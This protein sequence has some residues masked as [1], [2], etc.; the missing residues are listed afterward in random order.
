MAIVEEH[1]PANSLIESCADKDIPTPNPEVS[2][3]MSLDCQKLPEHSAVT[4]HE[5]D[6]K[7][8]HVK[9][10]TESEAVISQA[11]SETRQCCNNDG[12]CLVLC[13]NLVANH[14]V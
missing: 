14:S 5:E 2:A 12:L 7:C 3:Q 6:T 10:Q 13:R 8:F 1:Q 9:C 4:E 11:V